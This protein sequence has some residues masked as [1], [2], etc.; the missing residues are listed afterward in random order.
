MLIY[1]YIFFAIV[2]VPSATLYI[3]LLSSSLIVLV[4]R[5]EALLSITSIALATM[6][7]LV[8]FFDS[9]YIYQDLLAVR[10]S[11]VERLA[12]IILAIARRN[13]SNIRYILDTYFGTN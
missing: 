1:L 11:E 2:Y 13:S 7:T 10:V 3:I 8:G 9:R 12:G 5:I 4:I 6:L